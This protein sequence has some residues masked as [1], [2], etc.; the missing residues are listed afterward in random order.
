MQTENTNQIYYK[1]AYFFINNQVVFK[2]M[3]V[4]VLIL[5]NIFLCLIAGV[6]LINYFTNTNRYNKDLFN[7]VENSIN[8]S[9][10]RDNQKPLALKVLEVDKIKSAL[11]T[12]DLVAKIE[13]PNIVWNCQSF[14]YAFVIDGFVSDWQTTF[15]LPKQNKYLFKFSYPSQTALEQVDLKIEAT[16]WNRI[17]KIDQD[18]IFILKDFDITDEEFN[19]KNSLAQIKFKAN[20][21][22]SF[23]FWQVGWQIALYRNER[24]V[25][26]NYVTIHNFMSGQ[27][28]QISAAW[29]TS[30]VAPSR[31]EI[32]PDMDIFDENNYIFDIDS[33]VN[34]IR[35]AKTRY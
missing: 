5:I 15:I 1:I 2:R 35:G 28:R 31:I 26:V 13:N 29:N 33:P 18:R 22:S 34:L 30:L 11:D 9:N 3:I 8:W 23:S 21:Q 16:N 12:Y 6:G 10:Y 24:L 14:K 17:K 7:L 19:L 25:S 27:E 20:N 32:I 4:V